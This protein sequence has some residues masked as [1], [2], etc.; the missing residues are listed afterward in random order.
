MDEDP[1]DQLLGLEDTYYSEGFKLGE[2]DGAKAGLVE[3]RVFGL[4]KGFEKF[5][6]MGKLHGRSVVWASRLAESAHQTTGV[7]DED[8]HESFM[9]VKNNNESSPDS[10]LINLP[11]D[12]SLPPLPENAR[13]EKHV[14]TLFALTEPESLSLQNSEEDVSV[15]DD[16]FKRAVSKAVIVGKLVGENGGVS[17]HQ[18]GFISA[19]KKIQS[20]SQEE[21]GIEDVNIL[22]ARH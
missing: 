21:A 11:Q 7:G 6:Q 15:F 5:L 19:A 3:G 2:A 22:H 13:L 17:S 18:T 10:P 20:S 1:F 16:R 9:P 12:L 14:R 4:E 8:D